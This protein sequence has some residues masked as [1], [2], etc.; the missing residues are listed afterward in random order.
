L[1]GACSRAINTYKTFTFSQVLQP[2]K[3]MI[4]P[5][6]L[7]CAVLA[8]SYCHAQSIGIGT[9]TPNASAALEV[10]KAGGARS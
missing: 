8:G 4:K 1:P 10:R 9:S 5:V 2:E 6:I 7:I 3:N